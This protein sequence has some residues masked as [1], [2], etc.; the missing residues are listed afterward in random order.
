MA[1]NISG[2]GDGPNGE[3][4]TYTIHGRGTVTRAK[5][6]SEVKA[7]KHPHHSIYTRNNVEYVR[8]N[9]DNSENNNINDDD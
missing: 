8:S 5:L 4:N 2:N 1:T 6:V 3:N 7:E 9:P